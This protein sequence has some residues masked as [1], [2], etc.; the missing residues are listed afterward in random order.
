M[1]TPKKRYQKLMLLLLALLDSRTKSDLLVPQ[2]SLL[3]GNDL[4]GAIL[5]Y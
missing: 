3:F 2:R 4:V 1:K 5:C